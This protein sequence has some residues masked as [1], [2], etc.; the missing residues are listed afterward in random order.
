MGHSL[1]G[2]KELDMTEQLTHTKEG[3]SYFLHC[4]IYVVG[5]ISISILDSLKWATV[6]GLKKSHNVR[7]QQRFLAQE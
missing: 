1:W 5:D 3:T 4:E 7:E 6:Y 2:R